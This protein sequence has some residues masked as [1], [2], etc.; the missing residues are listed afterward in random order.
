MTK[1]IYAQTN[2]Y[3]LKI[4]NVQCHKPPILNFVNPV[5]MQTI[6]A[7]KERKTVWYTSFTIPFTVKCIPN[8]PEIKTKRS[9]QIIVIDCT[10]THKEVS[11]IELF[12]LSK[13]YVTWISITKI[14]EII[15]NNSIFDNLFFSIRYIKR[16]RER[17]ILIIIF[18]ILLSLVFL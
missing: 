15:L 5:K 4:P 11:T 18:Y 2:Q 17:T 10:I 12:F 7:N 8:Q 9:T 1:S 16:I 14:I 6:K 3:T 13:A